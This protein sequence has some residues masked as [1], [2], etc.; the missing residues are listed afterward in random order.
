MDRGTLSPTEFSSAVTA[1]TSAF[2]DPTRRE[3]YLFAR[4]GR[5]R[6]HRHRGGRAVRAP[7]QRGPPPSRQAHRRRL[8]RGRRGPGR[9]GGAGGPRS[10]TG[11]GQGRPASSC[12]CATTTCSS[13]CS[14]GR[15][16]CCRRDQ[17]E[18]MAEEVGI[19][20]GRLM[21]V[22]HRRQLGDHQRSFRSALHTVADALTAHGFAAH[23]EKHEQRA[24]H[25]RP[26]TARSATPA[27]EQ[28]GHLR[29]RPRDG[30]GHAHRAL[31]R[32]AT[33][34]HRVVVADGRR[35]LRHRPRGLRPGRSAARAWP[36][37][38]STTRPP[39]RPDRRSWPRWRRGSPSAA[40]ARSATPVASTPR[41]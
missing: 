37:T 29:G 4:A 6:R 12:P 34:R 33:A 11:D 21:A 39:R 1:I 17:A 10:A 7:P 22:S 32:D 26:S 15:S 14:A 19:E 9:H 41:A 2:G 8:P 28:P 5:R 30:E 35:R 20:Y 23:A 27:L 40:T 3:I 13:P 25:R 36:A 31:R 16:T 24:A 38:T 18:A